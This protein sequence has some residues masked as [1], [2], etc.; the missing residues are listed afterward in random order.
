ML[1]KTRAESIVGIYTSLVAEY[2]IPKTLSDADYEAVELRLR[3]LGL[4]RKRASQLI[5]MARIVCKSGE[6]VFHDWKKLLADVPGLGAYASRAITCFA[7]GEVVGIVDANVARIE[8]R[9]F[10]IAAEDPRAVIF[11]RYADEIALAA[12]DARETNF[13]LLDLGALV[14]LPA[15][16]CEVCPL[17]HI[18]TK[19]GVKKR[20]G[21]STR[22]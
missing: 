9:V 13:G 3:P 4:S 7:K 18:C 5:G 12:M 20:R 21:M 14:C 19:Y 10:R 2:P 11:Q 16:R 1:Q 8:R 22:K 15:P 6:A 17:D